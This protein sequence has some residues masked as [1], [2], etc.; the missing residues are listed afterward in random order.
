MWK[1]DSSSE[2]CLKLWEDKPCQKFNIPSNGLCRKSVWIHELTELGIKEWVI[3][4]GAEREIFLNGNEI[5][6]MPLNT[7]YLR[8]RIMIKL[9]SGQKQFHRFDH[10]LT[11]LVT[12]TILSSEECDQLVTPSVYEKLIRGV[13]VVNLD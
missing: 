11:S 7:L 1:P 2:I 13:P 9:P 6:D 3:K 4:H 8:K 10:V 12:L 5:S